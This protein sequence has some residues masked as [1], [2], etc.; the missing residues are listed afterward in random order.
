M[1]E[2]PRVWEP[3]SNSHGDWN[4]ILDSTKK[5]GGGIQDPNLMLQFKLTLSR[6][7]L[8]DL[9]FMG[10][11]FTWKPGSSELEIIWKR[12]DWTCA[13]ASWK[14]LFPQH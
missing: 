10:H 8:F 2:L 13:S 14:S 3:S 7:G 5:M 12:L 11:P 6:N 4:E 9:S 1:L